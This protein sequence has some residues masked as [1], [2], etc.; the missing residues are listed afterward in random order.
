MENTL[1][2]S[3]SALFTAIYKKDKKNV[4]QYEFS[5][6]D[7]IW[8]THVRSYRFLYEYDVCGLYNCSTHRRT[9]NIKER[10]IQL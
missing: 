6:R 1:G 4:V 2:R 9:G 5:F 7:D 8:A 3:F 10:E